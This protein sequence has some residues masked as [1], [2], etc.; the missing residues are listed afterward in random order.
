MQNISRSTAIQYA[1]NLKNAKKSFQWSLYWAVQQ[2]FSGNADG[3]YLVYLH[4]GF[5][6]GKG[7]EFTRLA[8]GRQAWLYL[9]EGLGLKDLWVWDKETTKF[10]MTA[11]WRAR[12]STIDVA[13][14][15]VRITT[16]LW[17]EYEKPKPEDKLYDLAEATKKFLA[18]AVKA[19]FPLEAILAEVHGQTGFE[20]D[21][22]MKA[23]A[24][25]QAAK[26]TE[27]ETA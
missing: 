11:G 5:L 18:G 20:L 24:A 13:D 26:S 17:Y 14:L 16:G 22:A 2:A 4:A 21:M 19:G 12:V 15:H 9:T 23:M 10:K 3:L 6:S 27:T 25:A 7:G 8:D 1:K